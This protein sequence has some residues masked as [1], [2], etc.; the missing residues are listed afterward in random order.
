MRLAKVNRLPPGVILLWIALFFSFG[1]RGQTVFPSD[2]EDPKKAGGADLLQAVCPGQVRVGKEITCSCPKFTAFPGKDPDW[3]LASMPRGHFLSSTSED[4]ALSMMGC[5]A[6]SENFGGTVLL[7]HRANRWVMLWYKAG[8][9]TANCHKVLLADGREILVCLGEYGAQGGNWTALYKEDLLA[10]RPVMMA[11]GES[12]FFH[13]YDDTAACG[14][15]DDDSTPGPLTRSFIESV[16]F[17]SNGAKSVPSVSVIAHLGTRSMTPED[18]KACT[19]QLRRHCESAWAARFI[20]HPKRYSLEFFYDGH[21]FKVAPA[22]A[23]T[24]KIFAA[25]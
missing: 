9:E 5:E 15:S 14:D 23:A 25:W 10:S 3:S 7:T 4:V 22:S 8:V 12:E 1:S 20:P 18:A 6:H 16:A 11:D 13:V 17:H 24:A 21:D 19:E 2:G